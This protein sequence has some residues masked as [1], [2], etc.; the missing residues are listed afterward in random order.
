MKRLTT[1]LL[2]LA[3]TMVMTAQTAREEIKA[4]R[5]LSG[6][7]Y[8]D[9]DRQRSDKPLTPAPKGYQ[10][11]YMTHYGRHGSRW[12][13]NERSYIRVVEP[14]RKAKETGKLTAK[15]QEVLAKLRTGYADA[16]SRWSAS[17]PPRS[18]ASVT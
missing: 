9:Y 6:G 17:C 15:G 7:N 14:L 8:L 12:L 10:P 3:V 11:F 13:I 18:S 4:N 5:Y 2:T 1:L 16:W